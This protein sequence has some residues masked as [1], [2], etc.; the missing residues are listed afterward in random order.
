MKSTALLHN[1]TLK[2]GKIMY[3]VYDMSVLCTEVNEE[4]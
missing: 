1:I 3:Y 2:N 4:K